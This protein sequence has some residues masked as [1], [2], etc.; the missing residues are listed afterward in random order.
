MVVHPNDFIIR[1]TAYMFFNIALVKQYKDA[2]L[3]EMAK[4]LHWSAEQRTQYEKDLNL[5]I[6]RATTAL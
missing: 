5:E 6:T 1:R 3:D 4:Q 2:I